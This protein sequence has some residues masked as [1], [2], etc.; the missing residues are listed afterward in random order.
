MERYQIHS[1]F[2]NFQSRSHTISSLPFQ[3]SLSLQCTRY[4][5]PRSLRRRGGW[6]LKNSTAVAEARVQTAAFFSAEQARLE[7]SEEPSAK[8]LDVL[9]FVVRRHDHGEFQSRRLHLRGTANASKQN[10][11]NK[12]NKFTSRPTQGANKL[13]AMP[14][15]SVPL[16][17]VKAT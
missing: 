6:L 9:D 11:S 8:R 3:Q 4:C 15:K 13:E 17:K 5:L 12:N 14:A 1:I 7:R 16:G 2:S 10:N